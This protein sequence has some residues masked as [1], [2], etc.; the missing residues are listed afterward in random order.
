MDISGFGL[1]VIIKASVTFPQGFD[2]TAFADDS[3]P[4]DFPDVT[5]TEVANGLNGDQ[6]TF[7]KAVSVK[8]TIAVIPDSDEDK[9]LAV[10]FE[11]NRA[12]RGKKPARDEITMT[13]VYPNG[14]TVT[15]SKG[16]ITNGI[17][18]GSVS[19][20]SRLKSKPYGF[21]FEQMSKSTAALQ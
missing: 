19:S 9:N 16:V 13:G 3:D 2:V 18:S 4:F 11:A 21:A 7:S 1:R 8:N 10:L 15:L 6:V 12:S 20:S 14:N 17:P 5:I